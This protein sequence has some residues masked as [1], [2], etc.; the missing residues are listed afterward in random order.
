METVD[1]AAFETL[2]EAE[3]A[4]LRLE[5]AGIRCVLAGAGQTG[6][7]AAMFSRTAT[8]VRVQVAS[9]DAEAARAVLGEDQN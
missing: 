6:L 8:K 7:P 9:D 5:S 4:R 2:G 1:V 3:L